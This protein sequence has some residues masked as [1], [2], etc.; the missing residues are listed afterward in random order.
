MSI[1][2]RIVTG[3][4]PNNGEENEES[5][6]VASVNSTG[7]R[8]DAARKVADAMLKRGP[9]NRIPDRNFFML[10]AEHA[11]SRHGLFAW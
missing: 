4:T 3:F 10:G 5:Q 11:H 2:E 7:S 9:L 8:R 1:C 6:A